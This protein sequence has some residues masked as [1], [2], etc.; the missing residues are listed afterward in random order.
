MQPVRLFGNGI[1]L[2]CVVGGNANLVGDE[3]YLEQVKGSVW[4]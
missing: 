3:P 2:L 1:T 4:E